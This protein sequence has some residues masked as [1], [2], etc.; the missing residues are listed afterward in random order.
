MVSE[1]THQLLC[2][3]YVFV[4]HLYFC[5]FYLHCILFTCPMLKQWISFQSL[6]SIRE[7]ADK[8]W[9]ITK[10]NITANIQISGKADAKKY[11]ITKASVV[12]S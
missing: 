1:V 12:V 10:R 4:M 7:E 5:F 9:V 3:F 11:K 6:H 2:G 8:I